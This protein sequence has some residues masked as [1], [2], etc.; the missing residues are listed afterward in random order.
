MP[1]SVIPT[2]RYADAPAA[3]DFLVDAFGFEVAMDVRDGDLVEHAQLTLGDGMVMLGSL[4]RGSDRQFDELVTT[5]AAAGRPTSTPY[6]V[7]EDVRA[8][9]ERARSAGAE[10]VMEPR[11]E[12][13]G[14]AT[15]TA[16]DPEGNVWTFGSYDP[17]QTEPD[18]RAEPDED[19][20]DDG[21]VDAAGA[22]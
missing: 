22:G 20:D 8:H 6:V 9:A 2:F 18:E 12:D 13:Y 15:Y 14:G 3:L 7:V 21:D 17:W 1:S 11:D 10:I 5:V 16:R 19:A 4:R